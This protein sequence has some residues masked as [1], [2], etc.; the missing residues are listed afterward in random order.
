MIHLIFI[1]MILLGF[2]IIY[3]VAMLLEKIEKKF[4]I[5]HEDFDNEDDSLDPASP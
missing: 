3:G 5:T 2:P 4:D 1:G